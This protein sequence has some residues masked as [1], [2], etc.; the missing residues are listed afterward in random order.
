MI[1][2]TEIER[3]FTYH[4]T[5]HTG[6]TQLFQAGVDRKLVKEITGHRSGAV[7]KYQITSIYQ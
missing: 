4:S 6:S 1:K 2:T 5:R 7:D 3:Y